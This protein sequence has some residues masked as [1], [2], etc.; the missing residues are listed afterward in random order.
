MPSSSSACALF[1]A[2]PSLLPQDTSGSEAE[3]PN[4]MFLLLALV[5]IFWFL[6]IGPERK[7]RRRRQDMIENLGK[8]DK[9]MTNGG[10]YGTVTRV[11]DQIVTLQIADGV[12]V[13]FSQQAIQ[14][15]VEDKQGSG[16]DRK[17][18]APEE[19]ETAQA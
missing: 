15:L 8:G 13:R 19:E 14:G 11:A 2:L 10:M 3:G 12:R 5:A 17:K 18:G 1:A 7:Q 16:E 6:V 9:V 4:M